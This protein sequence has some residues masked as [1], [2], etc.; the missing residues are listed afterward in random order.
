MSVEN[1]LEAEVLLFLLDI[2]DLRDELLQL[3]EPIRNELCL[4]LQ[5][6]ALLDKWSLMLQKGVHFL[7]LG[8][9]LV[10]AKV[11]VL[12]DSQKI[13]QHLG[14]LVKVFSLVL[15]K[16]LHVHVFY[17]QVLFELGHARF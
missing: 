12:C 9:E 6:F 16:E 5:V 4:L 15:L 2:F 8:E 10:D 14:F 7:E 1:G 13:F 3:R 17:A 11:F